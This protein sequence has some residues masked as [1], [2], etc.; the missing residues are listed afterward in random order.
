MKLPLLLAPLLLISGCCTPYTDHPGDPAVEDSGGWT[1]IWDGESAPLDAGWRMAGPGEFVVEDGS[2]KATG[3]MGLLW[4]AGAS[5]GDFSLSME[6]MV[7]D[8]TDNAG[9]FVRFPDPGEDP[10]VAVHQGYEL[11]ICDAAD[12]GQD[13]GSVFSF[14]GSTHIPTKPAGEWNHYLITVTGQRYV[15][16]VNGELVNDFVGERTLE[17]YVGLQNHDDGSPVRF[18]KLAVREL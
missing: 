3:G 6:W 11:Q 12:E 5:Y 9:V 14:Q 18:R 16:H 2:L 15:V 8:E 4:Y 13:T 1:S 17:G 10:W 7:E